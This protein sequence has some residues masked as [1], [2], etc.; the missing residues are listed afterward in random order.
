MILIAISVYRTIGR[1]SLTDL[2]FDVEPTF[3]EGIG[4]LAPVNA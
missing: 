1:F 3:D 4:L 2:A